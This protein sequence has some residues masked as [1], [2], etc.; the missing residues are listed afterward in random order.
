M[1]IDNWTGRTIKF[2]IGVKQ[3]HDCYLQIGEVGEQ[4]VATY[5]HLKIGDP[6]YFD[7]TLS[8]V[9][10]ELRVYALLTDLI[11]RLILNGEHPK[12]IAQLFIGQCFEPSGWVTIANES[13]HYKSIPDFIGR[14]ILKTYYKED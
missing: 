11:S 5:P 4:N 1:D 14:F 12:E 3:P 7:L 6:C 8:R 2:T 10:E 13:H 9:G